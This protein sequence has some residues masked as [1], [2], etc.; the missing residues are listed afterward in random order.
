MNGSDSAEIK[1]GS[2]NVRR[3]TKPISL[4][5]FF[6]VFNEKENLPITIARTIRT[7]EE[8]PFVYAYEIIIV[9]DGSK[10]GSAEL[11]DALA[12]THPTVRVVHHN[13]NKGY[14]SALKTGIAAAR[15]D[16][17]FFTDADLQFDIVEL[18]ALLV[19][20]GEYPVV[21]G[22]RAP[23]R[24]PFLRLVNAW[25]WN[26]LNRFLF[27]LRVRDI[28]C[29]FKIFRRELV[30]ELPLQSQG[31][32]IS[33]ETLIRL[34]CKDVP[35]KEVPVSHLPRKMGSPTGAKPSVIYRAFSEM[36]ELYRGELG[37]LAIAKTG[38][39]AVKFM[40]VGVVNTA[41]DAVAYIMLT[42]LT[43]VFSEHLIVA[44][45]LSFL[46]GTVSSLLLNRSW[47]FGMKGRPTFAEIVRFY[48]MT[49]LSITVN[50][51]LMNFFV[52]LGMYDLFALVITTVFTFVINFFLS[53]FWVFRLR[54]NP[55]KTYALS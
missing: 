53:K 50:V 41:L 32:M 49:S 2:R 1:R 52:S 54:S 12:T 6:P 19:H 15:M 30:Q 14:G 17:V 26:V 45:F 21:I 43:T 40:M 22:Y 16:Y 23:R 35:V 5:V 9:D 11:A 25:G 38:N 4:S 46:A 33:A 55:P 7:L 10:D 31:A 51:L 20:L 27:G 8:S 42:R 47:T 18:N 13:G 39:E 37:A 48:T 36:I 3:M 24:D 34:T 28:D 44:K 29:A